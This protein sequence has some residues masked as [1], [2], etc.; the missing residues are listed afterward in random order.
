VADRSVR[1]AEGSVGINPAELWSWTDHAF[2]A[3][4]MDLMEET[5]KPLLAVA[6]S[7]HRGRRAKGTASQ[8]LFTAPTPERAVST[9]ASLVRY[10]IFRE[11]RG[12]ADSDPSAS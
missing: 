8:A 4:L 3:R 5:G 7:E 10:S 11:K 12:G 1:N 9:A 2:T 6:M